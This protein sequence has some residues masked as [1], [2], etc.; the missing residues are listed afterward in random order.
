MVM[1]WE[2]WTYNL[3]LDHP[4]MFGRERV[5]RRKGVLARLRDASGP[6]WLELGPVSVFDGPDVADL[7]RWC[8]LWAENWAGRRPVSSIRESLRESGC[9]E[10]VL[11]TLAGTWF[12]GIQA[13]HM[14]CRGI[15]RR[16]WL[17]SLVELA[18]TDLQHL[19]GQV[20][21][22]AHVGFR[23]VKVK[24]RDSDPDEV[25]KALRIIRS[26][27]GSRCEIRVD[28]NASWSINALAKLTREALFPWPDMAPVAY[29]EDPFPEEG[30]DVNWPWP[31]PLAMDTAALLRRIPSRA[32]EG[33]GIF[34]WG[35]WKPFVSWTVRKQVAEWGGSVVVS[36]ACESDVGTAALAVL[37]LRRNLAAGLG[38]GSYRWLAENVLADRL[39]VADRPW[40]E[41]HELLAMSQQVVP[42]RLTLCYRG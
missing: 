17:T 41:L 35:V 28:I 5:V 34:Q 30:A 23:F 2:V 31:V 39:P 9:P 8:A 15:R 37:S 25:A 13:R 22:L 4:R 11:E 1:N 16:V 36:S 7:A 32:A 19:R 42:D 12:L 6:W 27:L 24:V 21:L 29:I 10:P 33:K 18:D 26:V 14:L 40:V 20:E 3:P 38:L